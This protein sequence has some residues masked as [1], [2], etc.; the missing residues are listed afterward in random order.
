MKLEKLAEVFN[1]DKKHISAE[2]M[3]MLVQGAL[4]VL[5]IFPFAIWR[6]V[7]GNYLQALV[8]F[9]IVVGMLSLAVYG[10]L[11]GR[12]RQVNVSFAIFYCVGMLVAVALQ[13]EKML[14]WAYPAAVAVFFVVR[15]REA[16]LI[17]FFAIVVICFLLVGKASG[18]Y[19]S[20]FIVTYTLVCLF[21]YIF[22]ARILQDN[23][24]LTVEATIDPLTGAGNR[25]ALAEAMERVIVEKSANPKVAV[26][27]VLFDI[28]YF[29]SINDLYGHAIG[30]K[31]LIRFAD[32]LRSMIRVDESL[33]R[34]GGEEFVVLAKG[35][36]G[37][38]SSLAH[39][40]RE[41]LE[42]TYLISDKQVTV[43]VGVAELAIGESARELIKRADDALYKAKTSG[44]NRVCEAVSFNAIAAGAMD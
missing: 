28:D 4:G 26:S 2:E 40:V 13:G 29:K 38:A 16:I 7:Q 34:F 27:L 36:I 22:A 30:D 11:K 10:A 21:A 19:L 33:Y 3:M 35:D 9:S 12:Y 23:R 8:D 39:Q 32:F 25:R 24:R 6:V 41:L 20:S 14:L 1:R 37:D 17:S 44:R 18:L 31:F 5:A 15:L 43:S 42:S